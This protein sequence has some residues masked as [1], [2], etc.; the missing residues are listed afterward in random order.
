MKLLAM[1]GAFVGPAGALET[2]ALAAVGGLL[3]GLGWA[4]VHRSF[5]QP[6]GFAPAIA[7]GAL[8][9]MLSPVHLLPLG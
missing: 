3:L 2:L 9:V 5:A 1:I 4:L 7:L 6:F 8:G